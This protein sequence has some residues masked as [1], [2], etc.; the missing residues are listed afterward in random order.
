MIQSEA[1]KAPRLT[2]SHTEDLP[3]LINRPGK[4]ICKLDF[5]GLLGTRN[6]LPAVGVNVSQG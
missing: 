5:N 6:I 1:D 3:Q 4:P 2:N